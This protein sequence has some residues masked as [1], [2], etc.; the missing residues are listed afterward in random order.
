MQRT[1]LPAWTV[2]FRCSTGT[3][4]RFKRDRSLV[5]LSGRKRRNAIITGTSRRASVK[6]T[7]VWQFAVLP[8]ADTNR[9]CQ[10]SANLTNELIAAQEASMGHKRRRVK[11]ENPSGSG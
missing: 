10:S 8:R 7:S 2:A 3:R 11:H 6:D 9:F 5:Q 1:K 4:A